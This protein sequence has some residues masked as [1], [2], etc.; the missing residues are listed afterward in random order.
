MSFRFNGIVFIE[1]SE[2]PDNVALVKFGNHV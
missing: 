2:V 1:V